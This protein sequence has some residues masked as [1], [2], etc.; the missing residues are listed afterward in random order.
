[1]VAMNRAAFQLNPELPTV[2]NFSGGRS[3]AYMLYRTLEAYG[4]YEYL[5]KDTIIAF[6]NTGKE[7]PETLDFVQACSDRWQIPIVWLEYRYHRERKGGVKE[8]RH[9]VEVVNYGNAARDGRPFNT[10]IAAKKRLPNVDKRLCTFYLKVEVVRWFVQRRLG[11]KRYTSCLGM[12]Y[13]EPKRI[14]LSLFQM[15][16]IEYPLYHDRAT[17]ES[18]LS[19]WRDQPFDLALPPEKSNCDL[20][21]SQGP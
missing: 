3:S 10:F 20:C 7:Y 11:W 1:M 5:P 15:C 14:K 6:A 16:Q 2:I 12:R 8:P 13:D 17:K 21:F 9:D 19:F 18:V 4:G